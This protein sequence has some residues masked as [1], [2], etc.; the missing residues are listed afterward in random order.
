MSNT[1]YK[2]INK[3]YLSIL[4]AVIC[5]VIIVLCALVLRQT[6][7]FLY[8]NFF[9]YPIVTV[10][11]FGG[12][13]WTAIRIKKL[14]PQYLLP[15]ERYGKS[16]GPFLLLTISFFLISRVGL[17]IE[18]LLRSGA[19]KFLETRGEL[20]YSLSSRKGIHFITIVLVAPIMEEILFRGLFFKSFLKRY[21]VKF[22]IFFS[23]LLF[24]ILHTD[25]NT[26]A[27]IGITFFS[28]IF[29]AWLLLKTN[30]IKIS[31]GCHVLWNFLNYLL[32]MVVILFNGRVKNMGDVTVLFSTMIIVSAI[33][34]YF[35]YRWL[36]KQLDFNFKL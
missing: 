14:D 6:A 29:Y 32:P 31:I 2:E 20:I 11:L 15:K 24:S 35:S 17:D 1:K 36:K 7:P 28:G 33:L 25:G 30:N 5:I 26:I 23:S 3:R 18:E 8:E 21:S 4:E 13:S 19:P 22:S 27:S 10:L 12:V 16:I 34:L 9:T